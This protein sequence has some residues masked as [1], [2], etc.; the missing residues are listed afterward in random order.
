MIGAGLY[1]TPVTS[2]F[3]SFTS[4]QCVQSPPDSSFWRGNRTKKSL[5]VQ[6]F[7]LTSKMRI[8]S[9]KRYN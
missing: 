1:C 7:F 6:H 2:T 9:K 5:V 3:F 8:T 4:S